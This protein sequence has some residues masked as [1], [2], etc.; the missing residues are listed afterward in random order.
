L[1]TTAGRKDELVIVSLLLVFYQHWQGSWVVLLHHHGAQADACHFCLLL[2]EHMAWC[3]H[4][5]K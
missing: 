5:A 4:Y 2:R 3:V 1:H